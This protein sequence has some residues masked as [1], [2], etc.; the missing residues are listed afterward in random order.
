MYIGYH[1]MLAVA[2]NTGR[3]PE[4]MELV[5]QDLWASVTGEQLFP[6]VGLNMLNKSIH[7]VHQL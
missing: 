6:E 4:L 2:V 5:Q 1:C 7:H 3:F